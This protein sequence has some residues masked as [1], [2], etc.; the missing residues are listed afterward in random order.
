LLSDPIA[1]VRIRAVSL[2]A[3]VPTASQPGADRESFDRA[4][5]EFLA[6]QRLNADR[7][8]ARTTLANFLAQRGQSAEAETEYK[9]ALKLS[10][11]FTPAAIN[12]A[13]LYRALE[14]GPDG[15]KV[16]RETVTA[17]PQDAGLHYA[18]GLALIR[19]K[20]NDEALAE[21]RRA[22]ELAPDQSQY[23]YVYA[24][25]Q[26][27]AGHVED[28]ITTLKENLNKH[29]VD[30][31]TLQALITFNRDA[32]NIASALDYA[33]R[34]ARSAPEDRR[35]ADLVEGLKRQLESPQR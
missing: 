25:G 33:Q 32:G 12:L 22:T 29:P 7:P 26:H 15:L 9:A 8:E 4:A 27:S 1:G 19:Q 35:I 14:R 18:F 21:L 31:Q 17:V 11:Q 6:A 16:L 3:G 24:V 5:A 20:Q 2:L 28:A 13:D 34:L 30:R 23:A 10:P